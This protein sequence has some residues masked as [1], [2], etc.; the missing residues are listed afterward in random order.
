MNRPKLA[1]A[2]AP[3]VEELRDLAHL[4]GRADELGLCRVARRILGAAL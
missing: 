2:A 1:A 3:C 4:I